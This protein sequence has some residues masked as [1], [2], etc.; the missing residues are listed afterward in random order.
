MIRIGNRHVAINV[1]S[2]SKE[3]LCEGTCLRISNLLRNNT[4]YYDIRHPKMYFKA[5][6][7]LIH[8]F[9]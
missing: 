2:V 5:Q 4:I 7:H 8:L 9:T 3:I 6:G 1:P